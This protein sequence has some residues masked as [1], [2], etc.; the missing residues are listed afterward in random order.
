MMSCVRRLCSEDYHTTLLSIIYIHK[1]TTAIKVHLTQ[2]LD[3]IANK[4]CQQNINLQ[5]FPKN[6]SK[7]YL[8]F[9]FQNYINPSDLRFSLLC[10]QI[11]PNLK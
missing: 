7:I 8:I 3:A 2:K 1:F 9:H 6:C 4:E 10:M 11:A 5:Q